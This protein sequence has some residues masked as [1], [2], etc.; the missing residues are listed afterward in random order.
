M[1][2]QE[3]DLTDGEE[4]LLLRRRGFFEWLKSLS[5]KARRRRE[6]RGGREADRFLAAITGE[7]TVLLVEKGDLPSMGR[8]Y[9]GP[10]V[11]EPP[12]GQ[13]QPWPTQD[14][15]GWLEV[16]PFAVRPFMPVPGTPPQGYP[17]DPQVLPR[18]EPQQD[19]R[20][21][22]ARR[23]PGQPP[24]IVTEVLL[25]GIESDLGRYLKDAPRYD[26]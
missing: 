12:A 24:T 16:P 13:K 6:E 26:D 9:H 20:E 22:P 17:Q 2:G 21:E 4:P 23:A 3:R 25:P 10:V 8:T 18:E 7:H 19:P 11:T 1:P 5:P 14:N 15:P